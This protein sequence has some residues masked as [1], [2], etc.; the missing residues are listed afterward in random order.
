M[1]K[2]AL[3]FSGYNQR[4]VISLCRYFSSIGQEFVIVSSGSNDT[5]YQTI[6]KN[7]VILER[8]N[9]NLVVDLFRDASNTLLTH[10]IYCP[11]SE[12]LNIFV[13][14]N[15]EN[16]ENIGVATGMPDRSAYVTVTNKKS[17]QRIL[18][19]VKG[20]K[21]PEEIPFS[22][23]TAPCI[24]KPKRNIA[25]GRILYPVICEDNNDLV[26]N[27]ENIDTSKYFLQKLIS[28][29]S[30]YI[31]GYLNK[32]G[33]YSYYW[34]ENLLQ[35]AGGKSIVLAR[36]CA[37]PGFEE[38]GLFNAIASVGYYGPIMAE[39]IKEED[40]FYY[41]ELNPRFWGPLQLGVDCRSDFLSLYA[42]EWFGRPHVTSAVKR[43]KMNIYYS[44]YLGA[45]QP[46][47]KVYPAAKY[48]KDLKQKI[49]NYDVYKHPDTINL[50]KKQ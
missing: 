35:Q 27:M 48:L 23:A 8:K 15:A 49:E 13:L 25:D 6:Y 37:N 7:N 41:I 18:E 9:K 16:L 26:K 47:L 30:Y 20:V 32:C 22:N 42:N 11:T 45:Q 28:G 44:W 24:I 5:I 19:T 38:S 12:Y 3:L 10:L 34:Q 29:Q 39:F 21:F 36:T 17:S 40:D 50:Y 2:V 4:T 46:D 14:K 31:C 33:R 43:H 1:K